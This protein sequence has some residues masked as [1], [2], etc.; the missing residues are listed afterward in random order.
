MIL[1]LT[2]ELGLA[3]DARMAV[4]SA[5]REGARRAAIEG[6][7]TA[8]TRQAV[9][10]LLELSPLLPREYNLDISP[11]YASYG[12]TVTVVLEVD[13]RWRTPLGRIL[14]GEHVRFRAGAQT[15]SE[16]VRTGT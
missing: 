1:F 14:L 3:L 10:R 7:D 15:R 5:A 16:K 8:A 11:A 13:Y 9:D 2:I 12:T 4:W 6:G